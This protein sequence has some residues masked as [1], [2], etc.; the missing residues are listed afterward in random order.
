[1]EEGIEEEPNHGSVRKKLPIRQMHALI[2]VV[3]NEQQV[4]T[5]AGNLKDGP[6]VQFSRRI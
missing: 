5:R 4:G 6:D 1:L 3:L 2:V